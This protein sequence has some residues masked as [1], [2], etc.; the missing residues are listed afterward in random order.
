MRRLPCLA[1]LVLTLSGCAAL[2]SIATPQ[3]GFRGAEIRGLTFQGA[4]VVVHLDLANPNHFALALAGADWAVRLGETP[5]LQGTTEHR[6]TVPANGSST[7]DLPFTI[8]HQDAWKALAGA[9]AA[10]NVPVPVL[11][12]IEMVNGPAFLQSKSILPSPFKSFASTQSGQRP[13]G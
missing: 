10:T 5:L 12:N 4:E 2:R 11:V 13:T 1:L 9:G 6:T 3:V 8:R 7:F